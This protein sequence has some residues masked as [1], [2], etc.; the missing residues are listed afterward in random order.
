M[1]E[2]CLGQT[3]SLAIQTKQILMGSNQVRQSVACALIKQ[4]V[5]KITVQFKKRFHVPKCSLNPCQMISS[6]N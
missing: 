4:N 2:K 1:A 5:G 3:T 6:V